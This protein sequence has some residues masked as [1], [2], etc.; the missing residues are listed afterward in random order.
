MATPYIK[1]KTANDYD[2]SDY[3]DSFVFEDCVEEDDL[4]EI[5]LK[6]FDFIDFIDSGEL[7]SGMIL[8]FHFG[9]L[10]KDSL[11]SSTH[12]AIVTDVEPKY[13]EETVVIRA[14]DKGVVLKKSENNK[15][16]K[17]VT[18]T[19]IVKEIA[20]K[21]SMS[22]VIEETTV[23]YDNL[24]QGGSNDFEF[25]QYL[26]LQE[27]KGNYIFYVKGETLYFITR[28]TDKDSILTYTYP[29]N[30]IIGF[31]PVLSDILAEAEGVELQNTSYNV[32]SQTEKD[33]SVNSDTEEANNKLGKYVTTAFSDVYKENIN[34][35]YLSVESEKFPIK[36]ILNSL[37]K[38]QSLKILTADLIVYGNPTLVADTILTM[39]G[40][41]LKRDIGNWYITKVSHNILSNGYTTTLSL[42]K[43]A[44]AQDITNVESGSVTSVSTTSTINTSKGKSATEDDKIVVSVYDTSGN[45]IGGKT[46]K[47]K[48]IPK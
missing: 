19:D 3:I 16:W 41:L 1:V 42:E 7:A 13:A 4:L 34:K 39:S 38:E 17:D 36:N 15:V 12:V 10:G 5:T 45:K 25:L 26:A 37:E 31:T 18:S 32:D 14:L 29:D 44:T 28:G 48:F 21:Y 40:K 2:L 8:N 33:E 23:V 11:T 30:D 6:D 20:T 43:N 27:T 24:P 9:Y 46:A 22:A 35:Q 47:G